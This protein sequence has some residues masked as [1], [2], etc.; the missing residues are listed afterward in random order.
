MNFDGDP[1]PH[2]RRSLSTPKNSGSRAELDL[3]LG[4]IKRL[5]STAV[6]QEMAAAAEAKIVPKA[7]KDLDSR[8]VS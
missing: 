5:E 7:E 1:N 8:Q 4:R 2:T 3:L 6:Y